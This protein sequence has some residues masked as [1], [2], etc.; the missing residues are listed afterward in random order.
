MTDDD[1]AEAGIERIDLSG[2]VLDCANAR[3]LA[4]FYLALLGWE[5]CTDDPED[6]WLAI[7]P[8]EGGVQIS[9]QREDNYR[10]PTWP[11]TLEEQQMMIHLDFHPADLERAHVHAVAVGAVPTPWQPQPHIRV[12]T[13]PAGHLFCFA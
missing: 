9:F 6:S 2:V 7:K 3:E 13:D 1:V 12:Y 8:A 10:P 11:T 5:L 4:D